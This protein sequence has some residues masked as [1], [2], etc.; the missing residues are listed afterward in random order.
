MKDTRIYLAAMLAAAVPALLFAL[1]DE[2]PGAGFN[3]GIFATLLVGG[4]SVGS[5]HVLF[6][7]LPLFLALTRL[8][9]VRWW[10]LT[11]GGFIAGYLPTAFLAWLV[12]SKA[13]TLSMGGLGAVGALAAWLVIRK[14]ETPPAR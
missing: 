2:S 13:D 10:T 5:A 7:G 3:P 11:A 8:H 4:L 1:V 9:L 14:T 6:L 12:S